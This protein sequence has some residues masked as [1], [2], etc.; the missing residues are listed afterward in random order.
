[1]VAL[2]TAAKE[3]EM[4]TVQL[5]LADDVVALLRESDQPVEAAAQELI[6]WELYRR[7]AISGGR[8]AELLGADRLAFIRRASALGIP[9]IDMTEEEWQEEAQLVRT[10]QEDAARR[11]AAE[12]LQRVRERVRDRN[13]DLDEEEA[14]RLADRFVRETVEEMAADGRLRFEREA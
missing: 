7:G 9:F 3:W 5:D 10:L 1:V 6:V 12:K 4:S 2:G 11:A 8:A 14:V 13:R